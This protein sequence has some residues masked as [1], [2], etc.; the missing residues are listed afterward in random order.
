MS[1]LQTLGLSPP[2]ALVSFFVASAARTWPFLGPALRLYAACFPAF[3]FSTFLLLLQS[4]N[5][6]RGLTYI[7]SCKTPPPA[8][9]DLGPRQNIAQVFGGFGPRL[10]L[11]LLPIPRAAIGDGVSFPMRAPVRRV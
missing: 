8:D 10:L 1:T 7:E 9:F 6:L 3:L 11:H 4:R 2:I 5:L